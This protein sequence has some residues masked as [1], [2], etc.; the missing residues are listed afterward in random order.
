MSGMRGCL[1]VVLF[2]LAAQ[3]SAQEAKDPVISN[4]DGPFP[5]QRPGEI[6]GRLSFMRPEIP[7]MR[8]CALPASGARA[9]CVD[10]DPMQLEYVIDGLPALEYY[11]VL[12]YP[13]EDN[14]ERVTMAY[15]EQVAGCGPNRTDCARGV[16]KKV[17]LQAGQRITNVDPA[18][19]YT[20]LPPRFAEPPR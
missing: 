2:A 12:A 8:V 20:S 7:P 1:V 18:S 9:H 13:Q 4:S 5:S 19:Y 15:A 16:L 17:F 11:Y 3:A 6:S 14:P 10:T